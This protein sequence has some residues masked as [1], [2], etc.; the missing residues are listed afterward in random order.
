MQM[1]GVPVDDTKK[2]TRLWAH[3]SLRVFHDRLV[4][5]EDRAWF[6]GQLKVCVGGGERAGRPVHSL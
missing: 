6:Q 2:L 3:E 4:S 1:A 5:D